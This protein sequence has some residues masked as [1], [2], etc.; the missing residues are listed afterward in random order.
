M[1]GARGL[2]EGRTVVYWL[3]KLAA[4]F[5]FKRFMDIRVDGVEHVPRTGPAI[6]I[7]NHPSAIDVFI[8]IHALP[9]RTY[10][11]VK[12]TTF[13][14]MIWD[15][16]FRQLGARP[17]LSGAD[18]R[19]AK[20]DA[21]R[22]LRSG[23]LFLVLPEGE[24]SRGTCVHPFRGGFLKLAVTEH[25]PVVPM[26]TVG[27]EHAIR[28]PWNPTRFTGFFLRHAK[29]RVE[30]LPP[31]HLENPTLDRALFAMQLSYVEHLVADRA[32]QLR[33]REGIQVR[34]PTGHERV[35]A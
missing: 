5:V 6:V 1:G 25:V 10:S 30:F 3:T 16:Y 18:N 32:Q 35:E 11:Y 4:A 9:R 13:S 22:A 26:V 33:L 19:K 23:H 12:A 15:W 21:G 14:S 34:E 2:R 7:G 20:D 27:S 28:D 24:V 29:I 17:V 31:L 8:G